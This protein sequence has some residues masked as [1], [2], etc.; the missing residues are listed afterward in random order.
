MP[1]QVIRVSF[2]GKIVTRN[3]VQADPKKLHSLTDM[4][5]PH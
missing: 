2:F 1:F 3:E 5:L 4:L